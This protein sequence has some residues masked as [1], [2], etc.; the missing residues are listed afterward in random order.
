MKRETD[1]EEKEKVGREGG[2]TGQKSKGES[3][4]KER[5]LDKYISSL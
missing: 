5:E 2:F 4:V 1:K 3:E